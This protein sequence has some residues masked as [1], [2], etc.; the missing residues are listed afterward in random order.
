MLTLPYALPEAACRMDEC[1]ASIFRFSSA[2]YL[3]KLGFA[4]EVFDSVW[5]LFAVYRPYFHDPQ[6]DHGTLT[7]CPAI[8]CFMSLYLVP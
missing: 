1:K 8:C 7:T 4:D 2:A 5:L 3:Q 6:G